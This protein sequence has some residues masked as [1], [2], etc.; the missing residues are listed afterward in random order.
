MMPLDNNRDDVG[1]DGMF[2]KD[3]YL[4]RKLICK[5][6]SFKPSIITKCYKGV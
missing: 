6:K 4:K 2:P 5:Q 3:D 1:I